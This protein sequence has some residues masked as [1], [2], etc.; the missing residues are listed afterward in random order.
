[1]DLGDCMRRKR[2]E[3]PFSAAPAEVSS[4]RR[5]LRTR[6]TLWGLT[7][8]VEQAQICM[9]ELVNNVIHHVGEGTQA[10]LAGSM[11]GIRLRLEVHDEGAAT[12]PT[13]MAPAADCE[14]GRGMQ[15]VD[16]LAEDWGVA[17]VGTG[18]VTWCELGTGLSEP[19]GHVGGD[20]VTN[21][22]ALL[23]LYASSLPELRHGL[24]RQGPLSPA[25]AGEVAGELMS[26]LVWWLRAHGCDPEEVLGRVR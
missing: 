16:A 22:E 9:T 20:R 5:L 11:R 2:W 14:S 21:A 15:I 13:A 10:L 4:L 24:P 23:M 17:A 19:N 18:K 1:M 7:D 8:V 6:L 3:V 25:S 12:V 26:D